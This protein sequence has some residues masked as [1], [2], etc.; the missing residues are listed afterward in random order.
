MKQ[1]ILVLNYEFPPLG[2]WAGP[3]SYDISKWYVDAGYNV[4][5]V[6][7]WFKDL[8]EYEVKDWIHIYRVKC[9]RLKKEV[10]HPWEQ[11]TYLVSW[12]FKLKEL[13]KEK[14]YD[15]CH[16]H[17]L[18]PTWILALVLKKK[19]WLKYIVTSH[20]SDVPWFNPDRFK[21]L[22]KFTP[23]ILKKVI[24][25]S[26]TVITPS[27]YLANLIKKNIKW[28][29]KDIQI[30]P[31]WI[32]INRFIPLKKEKIILWTWR[33]RPLKWLHL[34]VEAFSEIEDVYWYE[35]HICWDGPLM[36]KL[37][38]IQKKSKN[39][40][41]LHWWIDNK[42]EEYVEL[43][44][45]TKIYCL[46]SVSENG[47]VG[48]LEWMSSGCLIITT[49]NTWCA[50]MVSGVWMFVNP[51]VESIKLQLE[52]WIKNDNLCAE[53]WRKARI[54]AINNYDKNC[55]IWKYV[56]KVEACL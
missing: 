47:P 32:D 9:W 23:W 45:W 41:I 16:C 54:K 36:D 14:K 55:I 10:C 29:N 12:Y 53:L 22:H 48:I 31:N 8:P 25:G 38:E 2:W 44:W 26:E 28:I 6:T 11:L 33:L 49:G 20:W 17:F 15:L 30:I 40:I 19:F 43:L 37:V 46:P 18:V 3:V 24:N 35:L 13:L 34:L 51:T 39:K 42:S 27:N 52:Y 5:V 21:F 1:T 56:K 4:D 50:E 7:M